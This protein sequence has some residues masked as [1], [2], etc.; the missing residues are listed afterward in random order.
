MLVI[1]NKT[2]L[3]E[4]PMKSKSRALEVRAK[5]PEAMMQN[6]MVSFKFLILSKVNNCRGDQLEKY[7]RYWR[8]L[9]N[10]PNILSIISGDKM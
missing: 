3:R 6:K 4:K 10:D 1:T 8:K 9:T 2:L 5:T 7:V